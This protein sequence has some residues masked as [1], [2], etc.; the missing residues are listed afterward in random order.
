ML[1]NKYIV[2]GIKEETACEYCGCPL[3]TGDTVWEGSNDFGQAFGCS[4]ACVDKMVSLR[5]AK[6]WEGIVQQRKLATA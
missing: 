2:K 3:D 4:P 5:Y 1:W 6:R